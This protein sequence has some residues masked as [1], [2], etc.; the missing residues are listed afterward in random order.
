MSSRYRLYPT[1]AQE[2][3]LR[4]HCG[5]AR[6]VYNLGLEQRSWWQPGLHSISFAQQCRELTAARAQHQWLAEGSSVVQQQALR[7]L[8]RRSPTSSSTQSISGIRPF[9]ERAMEAGSGWS[10]S[11]SRSSSSAAGGPASTFRRLE[12]SGSG[13]PAP[14]PRRPSPVE[15]NATTRAAGMC[16]SLAHSRQSS[17]A[18]LERRSDWTVEWPSQWPPRR[19]NCS[20]RRGRA[21][22]S[23]VGCG[24]YSDDSLVRSA[25]P[26][27]ASGRGSRSA[28]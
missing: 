25:A 17:G 19:V 7:T 23:G 9:G 27:G 14:F 24:C 15:S 6:F 5:H 18:Q 21:W 20:R 8:P 22:D 10:A 13:Y 28:G 11:H 1:V 12:R 4:A 16:P 2:V 3:V 26:T